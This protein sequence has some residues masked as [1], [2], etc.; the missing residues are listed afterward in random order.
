MD[1]KGSLVV[2]V[3][4]ARMA[5]PVKNAKISIFKPK[6]KELLGFRTSNAEGLSEPFELETPDVE[7]SLNPQDGGNVADIPFAT[8]DVQIVHPMYQSIL[9]EDVQVFSGR[10]SI[11]NVDLIPLAEY[12]GSDERTATYP[13]TPQPL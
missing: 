8:L 7:L 2:F 5:I 9:I 13:I 4:T 6:T 12:A 3:T 10:K 1:E 11:Q